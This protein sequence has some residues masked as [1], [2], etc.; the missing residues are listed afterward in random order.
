MGLNTQ[1]SVGRK[2]K[3][4]LDSIF[5][6]YHTLSMTRFSWQT[7]MPLCSTFAPNG[8]PNFWV[9]IQSSAPKPTC[10]LAFWTKCRKLPQLRATWVQIAQNWAKNWFLM[11]P[12][13]PSSWLEARSICVAKNWPMSISCCSSCASCS[14][15]LRR[16]KSMWS[17]R[18]WESTIWPSGTW[19]RTWS[20]FWRMTRWWNCHSTIEK[21]R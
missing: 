18:R 14:I 4:R 6:N 3:T 10:S 13:L 8:V 1:N 17:I 19:M 21:P 2:W 16:G 7:T 15:L 9:K 11:R 12:R 5:H 20:T